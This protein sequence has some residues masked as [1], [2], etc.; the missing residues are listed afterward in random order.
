MLQTRYWNTSEQTSTFLKRK[1]ILAV[2][3]NDVS[4][5]LT[6]SVSDIRSAIKKTGYGKTQITK[7]FLIPGDSAMQVRRNGNNKRRKC[8]IIFYDCID[9]II[10]QKLQ[11]ASA[12]KANETTE[13]GKH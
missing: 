11:S 9:T 10:F 4:K 1:Y 2:V 6:Y 5:S 12:E 7:D 13:I 8:D 3:F